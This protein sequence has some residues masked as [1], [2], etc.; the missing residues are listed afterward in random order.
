MSIPIL[1]IVV[2]C[3]NEF[4]VLDETTSQLSNVLSKLIQNNEV[5]EKSFILYVNDGSKDN[6]WIKIEE[7]YKK[8]KYVSGVNL[9]CNAGHQN[10]V[11]AG[12]TIAKDLSDIMI[13]IDADLQDDVQVINDMVSSYKAGYDI[14]Y[15]VRNSRKKDTFLKRNSALGFYKFMSA[16]GVKSVYNHADYRLMSKRAVIQLMKFRERNLF[17]RGI[18]P[19]IGYNT[20]TVYY[21]RNE[22]FAGESKYTLSKMINFALDGITSFSVKPMRLIFLIG[23]SFLILTLFLTIYTLISYFNGNVVAGWTSLILSLWFIG[24]LVLISIG[25]VGEYIGKIYIEVKDRPRFNIE[26]VLIKK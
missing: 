24:A 22:R 2:P 23:L 9:A 11:M 1:S 21:S 13:T 17:L 6:T 3:Y 7:L 10:A 16:L 5:S 25:I 18:V 4:L 20:T 15:G 12:L 26:T 19:L 14:V 8:N